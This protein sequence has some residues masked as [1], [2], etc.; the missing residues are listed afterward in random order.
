MISI[1][2]SCTE[3]SDITSGITGK[4]STAVEE[5]DGEAVKRKNGIK[6]DFKSDVITM[7]L[8]SCGS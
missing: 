8:Y 2:Q 5:T 4:I 7:I 6:L 1:L 3:I